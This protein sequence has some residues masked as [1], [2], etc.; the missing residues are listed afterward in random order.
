MSLSNPYSYFVIC[1]KE[2]VINKKTAQKSHNI[3]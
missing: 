3:S 1:T 2:N